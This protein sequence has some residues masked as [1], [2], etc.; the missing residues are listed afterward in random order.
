MFVEPRARIRIDAPV[1]RVFDLAV[2][3]DTLTRI[4]RP[5][6]PI[7]GV[8]SIE[9]LGEGDLVAG[10]QRRVVLSD[11]TDLIEEITVIDRPLRHDYFWVTAPPFPFSIIVRGARASW[12]FTSEGN[13]TAVEWVYQLQLSTLFVYPVAALVATLFGRWMQSGLERLRDIAT[14]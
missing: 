10:T 8:E 14:G 6:G 9:V 7:P 2:A 12:T 11:R 5:M 4:L 1:E 13:G 3:P